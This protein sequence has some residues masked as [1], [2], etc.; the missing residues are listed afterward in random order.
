MKIN[1]IGTAGIYAKNAV[2]MKARKSDE[3]IIRDFKNFMKDNS[4]VLNATLTP[5]NSGFYSE[6]ELA[7]K[8]GY[9]TVHVTDED[10]YGV[11]SAG[12]NLNEAILDIAKKY[13]GQKLYINSGSLESFTAPK[14]L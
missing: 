11:N 5:S 7:K 12:R 14:S 13:S 8:R 9:N 10:G 1:S 6:I 3:A 2:A 4:L